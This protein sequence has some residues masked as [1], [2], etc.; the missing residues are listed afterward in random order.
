MVLSTPSMIFNPTLL[1]IGEVSAGA[2]TARATYHIDHS[3][4]KASCSMA[5]M[6]NISI[7][8]MGSTNA[9]EAK[10][11]SW[12]EISTASESAHVGSIGGPEC[13]C[14]SVAQDNSIPVAYKIVIPAAAATS[15]TVY[16]KHHHRFQYTG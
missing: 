14:P 7:S 10:D 12:L 13:A 5:V 4:A 11:E 6:K 3:V 9:S 2:S 16:F 8:F 1:S 15:G